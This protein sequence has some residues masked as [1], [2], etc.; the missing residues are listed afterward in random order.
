[1]RLLVTRPEPDALRLRAALEES[2]HEATVEP[3]LRVQF[4]D[5]ASIELEGVQSLI[6]TSRNGVRAL[7][8][9]SVLARARSVPLFAVGKVTAREA[10]ALGFSMVV[11]GAGT[12]HELVTH[13]V[14]AVDPAAGL[15]LHLAGDRVAVDL[16]A[17]LE[18]HGFRVLQ[19]VVYRT[20]PAEALSDDTVGQLAD[21]EIDGVILMSARTAEVYAKLVRTHRLVT[22]VQRLTHFCMSEA[23]ARRLS[24]LGDIRSEVADS[25][26][27]EVLL[28][29]IDANA[30][31]LEC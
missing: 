10:R 4:E 30:A 29:L 27:L 7:K 6:A 9:T 3:L 14:S 28:A 16:R 15:L 17:E 11:T 24:P 8:S 18:P 22:A 21:G 26:R 19:P 1:M 13:I 23:I 31:Q 20:L 5:V 25:P 12:A 2:G